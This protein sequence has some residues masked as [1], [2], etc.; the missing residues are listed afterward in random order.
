MDLAEEKESRGTSAAPLIGGG[1]VELATNRNPS[2]RESES[3]NKSV[4]IPPKGKVSPLIHPGNPSRRESECNNILKSTRGNPSKGESESHNTSK[5]AHGNPSKG[6]SK[7][8]STSNV[9]RFVDTR[10]TG[11]N[12]PASAGGHGTRPAWPCA[13]DVQEDEKLDVKEAGK[14]EPKQHADPFPF[15]TPRIPKASALWSKN[16]LPHLSA[17]VKCPSRNA[18]IKC[19]AD[20]LGN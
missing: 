3:N 16:S 10:G 6:E 14:N 4:A 7:S 2:M 18:L 15:T 13:E 8:T 11:S 1:D 12:A 19:L 5:S 17:H 9:G 20:P